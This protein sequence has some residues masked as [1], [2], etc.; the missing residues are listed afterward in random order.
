MYINAA[1]EICREIK[2]INLSIIKKLYLPRH[3][4]A[5]YCCSFFCL[6]KFPQISLHTTS[7]KWNEIIFA[8][9]CSLLY[10]YYCCCCYK[11][12]YYDSIIANNSTK[13]KVELPNIFLFI[14]WEKHKKIIASI[15]RKCLIPKKIWNKI[16]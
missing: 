9:N 3:G 7:W 15:L 16:K 4:M 1:N 2:S 6:F 11:H 10:S 13:N 5:S 14:Q 12:Y 8:Y